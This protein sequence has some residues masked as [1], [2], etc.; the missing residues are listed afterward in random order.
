[1]GRRKK[2]EQSNTNPKPNK[3]TLNEL[4]TNPGSLQF[5]SL[6][7][8]SQ[9]Q[10]FLN[11]TQQEFLQEKITSSESLRNIRHPLEKTQMAIGTL[12]SSSKEIQNC[13]KKK[14]TSFV[15][16]ETS[17][18]IGILKIKL[19]GKEMPHDCQPLFHRVDVKSDELMATSTKDKSVWIPNI[20]AFEKLLKDGI[21]SRPISLYANKKPIQA[22]KQ[23]QAI[24]CETLDGQ[25]WIFI[26]PLLTLVEM[27][28]NNV[29][30]NSS[31]NPERIIKK[32]CLLKTTSKIQII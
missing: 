17:K 2:D 27:T 30:R 23:I 19:L 26:R 6:P 3:P 22:P 21:D 28:K 10:I 5:Y 4:S 25:E 8:K 31:S 29:S 9:V 20:S 11:P 24:V 18:K 14:L 15:I 7:P 32:A 16:C 1:M 13:V 12:P